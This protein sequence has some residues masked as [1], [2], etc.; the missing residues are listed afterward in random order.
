MLKT[1]A[2]SL[3]IALALLAGLS[4][5]KRDSMQSEA[6]IVATAATPLFERRLQ[7]MATEFDMPSAAAHA[8][9]EEGGQRQMVPLQQEALLWPSEGT[10]GCAASACV[11]SACAGSAC[12]NSLCAGSA[13]VGQGCNRPTVPGP[14]AAMGDGA[15]CPLDDGGALGAVRITAFEVEPADHGVEIR[16]VA[17][18][19]Q[20]EGYRVYREPGSRA[21]A[22]LVAEG[23]AS[24]DRMIRVLDRAPDAVGGATYRLEMIDALGRVI[25]AVPE[26]AP[27]P[28]LA[29]H[30]AAPADEDA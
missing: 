24:S 15:Y 23:P 25:Q 1:T 16:W 21:G 12:V 3:A 9:G 11:I 13:C 22:V 27:P 10:S 2:I 20:V 26:S 18:G 17:T 19:G 28:R 30:A 29:R 5:A 7:E 14:V 8:P 4:V 6:E